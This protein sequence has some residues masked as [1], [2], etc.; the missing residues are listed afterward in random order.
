MAGSTA[1]VSNRKG[2][3]ERLGEVCTALSRWLFVDPAV[4]FVTLSTDVP[5]NATPGFLMLPV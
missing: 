1:E 2:K 3:V 5:P 4:L